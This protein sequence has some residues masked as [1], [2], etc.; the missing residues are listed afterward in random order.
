MRSLG[1]VPT[2][3]ETVEYMKEK[4]P[5]IEFPK[6]LEIIHHENQRKIDPV[7]ECAQCFKALD[8][9]KTGYL[10]RSEFFSLLTRFG[11]KMDPIEVEMSLQRMGMCGYG[12]KIPIEQLIH[13]I[14]GPAPLP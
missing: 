1:H 8:T 13:H 6:F 11:E 7:W 5:R 10:S 12:L 9:R 3:G 4:G 2:V 14:S